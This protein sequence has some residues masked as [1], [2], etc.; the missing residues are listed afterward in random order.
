M[1]VGPLPRM[2]PKTIGKL[3]ISAPV[4]SVGAARGITEMMLNSPDDLVSA[5]RNWLEYKLRAPQLLCP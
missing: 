5:N 4:D 3:H 1:T 2:T